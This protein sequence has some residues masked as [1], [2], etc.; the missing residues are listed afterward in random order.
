MSTGL[1]PLCVEDFDEAFKACHGVAPYL[2]QKRLLGKVVEHGA[3]PATIAAPTGAGKTAVLDVALFHLALTAH[4]PRRAAPRRIVFAVDRRIIVDQAFER[5]RHIRARLDQARGRDDALGRMADRLAGLSS[6]TALHV[7]ELRGGIP[8]ESDWARRPDQPTILCTTIDQLGSRLLF[9]GYGVSPG[10]APIHA[11]LLGMDALLILDEAH[12]SHAF[13]ETLAAIDRRR[14]AEPTLDLPWGWTALT[15]TPRDATDAQDSFRLTEAERAEDTIRRRLEASKIAALVELKKE[16]GGDFRKLADA[17][18]THA[19]DVMAKLEQDGAFAPVVGVV[20]NRVALARAVFDRLAAEEGSKT[21]LLTGRVR[22]VERDKLVDCWRNRLEGRSGS[23]DPPL[24]VVATQCIE[25]GADFDFDGMVSQIAPL[26]ALRQRFGRLARSGNRNGSPAPGGILATKA[27]IAAKADDPIYGNRMRLTWEW[28]KAEAGNDKKPSV[29]FGPDALDAR[30][31]GEG[32]DATPKAADCVMA[33][34]PAPLLRR[35]DLDA[36]AM[37][38]PRPAPDPDPSLF[39]HGEFR[40]Q[41]DVSIVWRADVEDPFERAR[42]TNDD[43]E[44]QDIARIL[45]EIV[46]HLLPRPGEALALPVWR[47][48]PWLDGKGA[49]ADD[50]L[51]DA[52]ARAPDGGSGGKG[53]LVLRWRGVAEA[54]PQLIHA[55]A[56]RPGDLVILPAS[57]GGCDAYGWAPDSTAPVHDIAELAA[58]AYASRRAALRLHPKLW[59]Q[60]HPAVGWAEVAAAIDGAVWARTLAPELSALIGE[61]RAA[62]W[63]Q[64]PALTLARPYGDDPAAGAIL[65]AP[66][67]LSGASAEAEPATEDDLGSFGNTASKLV[68][69][70]RHVT[71]HVIAQG[72]RLGLPDAVKAALESAAAWHDDGKVDPRFQGFLRLVGRLP[73]EGATY[74]K[75]GRRATP[76]ES[77]AARLRAG[78]PARWRHEVQSVRL[79]AARLATGNNNHPDPDLVLWL[80]G[81]HH[82]QGRPF[83]AHDD[84]W[85]AHDDRL[86]DMPLPAAP[87][88][89]KLDFDW[90]GRDWAGL[91]ADLQ[92]RYGVWGLAFLEA[93]LRLAD[94]R[95]SAEGGL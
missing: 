16:D 84:D 81:T 47:V 64:A 48:G 76:T 89:D 82:G 43:R 39:M 85:D 7:A 74:A 67:G 14:A 68:D 41:A 29:D 25:A 17:F 77:A 50:A 32:T 28:L 18:A 11:G 88:P 40:T 22:P 26:D 34:S 95:A 92:R 42:K 45:A 55:D 20:V 83:F 5:A 49:A 71:D 51:A 62:R 65:V 21:I 57:D 44:R 6:D 8:R 86:L 31:A 35:A 69:H 94:H 13:A 72:E 12:L 60:A 58:D 80:I 9:R 59:Q 90:R 75:S 52:E 27:D 91:M 24:F 38:A 36:F 61:D 93:C 87:G 66:K 54:Q 63:Q 19:R 78:L 70:T 15:A 46:S 37:T 30:I 1:P 53:R 79:A 73:D 2:W 3:W 33:A 23:D 4:E 10:M 56:I